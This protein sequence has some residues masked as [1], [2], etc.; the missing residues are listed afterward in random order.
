VCKEFLSRGLQKVGYTYSSLFV[1]NNAL[2][3]FAV[4]NLNIYQTNTSVR[5][6]NKRQ[7]NKLHIPSAKLS[8]E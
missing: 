5:G 8:I 7:Q 3:L 4:K 1:Y 6:M 2:K